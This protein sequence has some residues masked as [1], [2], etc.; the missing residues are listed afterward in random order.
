MQVQT[1]GLFISAKPEDFVNKAGKPIHFQKVVFM[2]EGDDD[3]LSLNAPSEVDFSAL[4][5]LDEAFFTLRVY[6]DFKGYLQAKI[7]AVDL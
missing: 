3:V 5:K 6:K 2:P 7:V 4:K 1:K